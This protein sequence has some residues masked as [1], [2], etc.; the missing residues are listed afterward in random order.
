MPLCAS[1]STYDQAIGGPSALHA[2]SGVTVPFSATTGGYVVH[3]R[4]QRY[5]ADAPDGPA[6]AAAAALEARFD[7]GSS[8][9]APNLAALKLNSQLKK[10]VFLGP[11]EAA[12]RKRAR[13]EQ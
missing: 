12:T 3:A 10:R 2:G 8:G 13:P 7:G 11:G 1:T 6:A 9:A 4:P 5:A